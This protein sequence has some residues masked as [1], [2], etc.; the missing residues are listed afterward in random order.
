MQAANATRHRLKFHNIALR[1]I[2]CHMHTNQ[3]TSQQGGGLIT[4]M[5]PRLLELR[6]GH[7]SLKQ[8][9]LFAGLWCGAL[10][11]MTLVLISNNLG[12]MWVGIEATTLL[13]AFLIC[14]HLT[15]ASLEAMWKYLLICSVGV[16]FAFMGTLLLRPRP[17]GP[18][19]GAEA[20]LWTHLRDAPRARSRAAEGRLHLPAGRLR[21][22]GRPGADAQL[23]AGRAQPGA[24]AR[25]RRSSPDSC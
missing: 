17:R 20:L 2:A 19:C 24:G 9:R 21:H 8:A 14:I 23:A 6:E 25:Y 22:Q 16:A 12:I 3:K 1:V 13:T 11:A 15:P 5:I 10:A 18:T 4:H 7:L